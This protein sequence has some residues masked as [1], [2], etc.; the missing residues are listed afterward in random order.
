MDRRTFLISFAGAG[1]GLASTSLAGAATD[2]NASRAEEVSQTVAGNLNIDQGSTLIG[3]LQAFMPGGIA[4]VKDNAFGIVL[5]VGWAANGKPGSAS[6]DFSSNTIRFERDGAQV[7]FDWGKVGDE[8]AV[9]RLSSDKPLK[10]TLRIPVR[11]W[12]GFNNILST[13]KSEIEATAIT[14]QNQSTTWVLHMDPFPTGL[15]QSPAGEMAFDVELSA[16]PV[17]IAAGFTGVPELNQVDKILDAAAAKYKSQR[18]RAGGPWGDF[19]GAIADNLNNSRQY[20]SLTKRVVHVIGRGGSWIMTDPDYPPYFAWDTSFNA[21][22][23]SLEDPRHA[24][25]TMRTLLSYQLTNGMVAQ[26]AAWNHDPIAYI[27]TQ[28]S[29]PPVTSLCAWKIYQRWPDRLFLAEVYERLLRWHQWWPNFSDGNHNGLLEWGALGSF[30]D[31]RLACGWDDTPAFDGAVQ[32]G[33]QMNADAVDLNS[34]WSMDAEYLAKMA[35]ELGFNSDAAE[36]RDGRDR[37]NQRMNEILWNDALGM[38]CTRLWGTDGKPGE[39]LTRLTPMN[40]YPLMCGAPSPERAARVM[41]IL[42]DPKKFWGKWLLPTLA[43]DDPDWSKQEYWKGHVWAPVNYLVWQGVRRYGTP[44]QKRYFVESSVELFMRNWI[45]HGTCNENYRST[46]GIGSDYPHYTWGAL[47]CQIG[48][49]YCYEPNAHG[50]PLP[51]K[52][53]ASLSIVLRNMPSGGKLYSIDSRGGEWS[54]AVEP[55]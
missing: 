27:N 44:E 25:D 16:T 48:L 31:A 39:F 55:E 37:M 34:L 11:P 10:L 29:N 6:P 3:N 53:A 38:Y 12:H 42:T 49:E 54:V 28:N 5:D 50:E 19:A 4:F 13:N 35:D 41:E 22:L 15:Q 46:D 8:A 9:A 40:F 52:D 36:L 7:L 26:I 32:V 43:Y 20:S 30:A 18:A 14:P 1:A 33:T 51:T 2:S 47:L 23:G 21:L 24:M 17:Y 45:E